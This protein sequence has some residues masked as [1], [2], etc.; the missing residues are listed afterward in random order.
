M[1]EIIVLQNVTKEW[2]QGPTTVKALDNSSLSLHDEGKMIAI[3]GPSG[4]GKTTLLNLLGC[5]DKPTSGEVLIEGQSTTQM[6]EKE[7]TELRRKKIG[8]VFQTFNL[9][10]TLT[11][12]ENV[13]LP[14]EYNQ[15]PRETRNERAKE[16]LEEVK[17]SHRAAHTPARLSGGEQQRVAIARAFANDPHIVLADEPTGNLDSVTG[18]EIVRLLKDEAEKKKKLIIVVTHDEKIVEIADRRLFIRDGKI[19]V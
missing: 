8:F 10:P 17:I 3:I 19:G 15:V 5:L 2:R 6:T 18:S 16:L 9:I 4:S 12:L 7:L 14:M 1:N 11:A 13:M